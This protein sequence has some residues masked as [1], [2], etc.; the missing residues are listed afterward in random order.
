MWNQKF[1]GIEVLPFNPYPPKYRS[2]VYILGYNFVRAGYLPLL[3]ERC[4]I[5]TQTLFTVIVGYTLS[6]RTH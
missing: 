2:I 3:K 5:P 6:A 1:L 4:Y